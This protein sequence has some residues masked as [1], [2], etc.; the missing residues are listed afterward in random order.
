[1][2]RPQCVKA[3]QLRGTAL[4]QTLLCGR[5]PRARLRRTR[6][7]RAILGLGGAFGGE[8]L[9][10]VLH[11]RRIGRVFAASSLVADG[12]EIS[13]FLADLCAR[14][15]SARFLRLREGGCGGEQGRCQHG[16]SGGNCGLQDVLQ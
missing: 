10:R 11:L 1:M 2:Q 7:A 14:E 13:E 15:T 5:M 4:I 16:D 6:R 12:R 9:H 3:P 8:P